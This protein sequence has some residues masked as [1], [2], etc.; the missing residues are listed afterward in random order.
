MGA[1]ASI[2]LKKPA[3]ASDIRELNSFSFAKSEV[4]RLR[5]DLGHLAKEH[6]V[7]T[8]LD[9][10]A[11]DIVFGDNEDEDYERCI[12]E[13]VHIRGCLRLSTQGARRKTRISQSD[14]VFRGTQSAVEA[15]YINRMDA[16]DTGNQSDSSSDSSSSDNG[17]DEQNDDGMG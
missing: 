11:S 17:D 4:C 16:G 13:I 7:Q 15:A 9:E 8:A 3:D 1:A 10:D 5:R 14:T 2:E 12:R 6:N